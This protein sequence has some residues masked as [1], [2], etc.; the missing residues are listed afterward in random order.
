MTIT[1]YEFATPTDRSIV[2]TLIRSS[3]VS[4]SVRLFT[5][6]R[7]SDYF[8]HERDFARFHERSQSNYLSPLRTICL[9][10]EAV[11]SNAELAEFGQGSEDKA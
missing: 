5:L 4:H 7:E 8:L 6:H 11:R 9:G 1:S 10:L 3:I 2:L